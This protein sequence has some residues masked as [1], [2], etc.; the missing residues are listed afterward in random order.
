VPGRVGRDGVLRL[1]FERRDGRTVLTERRFTLPLQAL[2]PV[3]LDDTGGLTLMLLNPTGGILGGDALDT[4]VSLG[5]GSHVCLTTPAATRVYRSAGPG[6]TQ[7]FAAEVGEGGVLEYFPDHL[8]P[9]PGARLAQRLEVTLAPGGVFLGVDAWAV[10]RAARGEAWRFAELDTAFTVQDARGLLLCERSVLS[11]ARGW[12]GLGGAEGHAYVATFVTVGPA[13]EDWS[14][15][16]VGMSAAA[17]AASTGS[18]FAVTAL[19]CGG[20]LAR[21]LC[22][23]APSLA[24][25]VSTLWAYCRRRLLDLPPLGL[26]KL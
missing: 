16:A 19:G 15:L 7:R 14:T 4:F 21:L 25:S 17:A 23:S 13:L 22:P 1:A 24:E 18:R 9:S 5:A 2:E 11:G 8:I 3:D 20:A 12:D 10:G 26:R 6:A